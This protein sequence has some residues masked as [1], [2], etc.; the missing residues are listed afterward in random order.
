MAEPTEQ[1]N[2]LF[3]GSFPDGLPQDV[4]GEL[5]SILQLH[6]IEPQELFY[7]WES[8]CMKMAGEETVLNLDTVRSFKRSLHDAIERESR[9]KTQMRGAEKRN[10]GPAAPRPAA[11]ANQGIFD[12]LDDFA[13]NTP[14]RTASG[15]TGSS[16]KRKAFDT[17]T[18]SRFNKG[19]KLDSPGS[20]NTPLRTADSATNGNS[21]TPFSARQNSGQVI[22]TL[23]PDMSM[24]SAPLAPYS[25]SRIRLTA[26]T[27]IKKFSYKPMAMKL[28]EASEILD[29]RIDEFMVVVQKHH[30][31]DDSAFGNAAQQST[32]EVVA[33]GRI[34]SDSPEGKLNTASIV[35][36]TSR[37]TG[38]GLRV[39]LKIDKLQHINF[40]PGQI[41]ALRGINASGEY[42]TVF[43][44]LTIPLLPL[45]VSLPSEVE[46]TNEKLDSFGDQPLNYMF[47]AGPYTT[48][49]NLAFEALNTLCEKAAEECV[50]ALILTGPFIDLEHPL[51]AAGDFDL[52]ELKGLD[53]DTATLTTLF[54]HC[55]SRPLTQLASKVPNIYII[56]I[57]SVR[58]AV[59]KHVSWPQEILPKKE[60]GLPPK[61]AKVVTNPVAISLN[62][63]MVGLCAS[64][65]LYELRRE[66]VV[67]GRPSESDLLS[68]LPRYLIE[69]RHFS[70]VFP[71]TAR[72]NLPK[73]GVEENLQIGSM[74]DT[75]YLKLGDWWKARPDILITPSVL[76]GFVKVVESVLV[77]NPGKL[78]KRRGPGTYAQVAVHP[79]RL[80][81]EERESKFVGHK[82]YERARVDIIRI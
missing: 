29:D 77:I 65:S 12:I 79:K 1:L 71:P 4:L 68:R 76:P 60:L 63:I 80:A 58:D 74:L 64:D 78:S 57:P 45:P 6:A 72:E 16:V 61:Q 51:I 33:V 50:D 5:L 18:N 54:K 8:Y 10:T 15:S 53:P 73:S 41:V 67:G 81:E 24:A 25:D 52:P 19:A 28:S 35:L 56:L 34:A 17:P 13:P 2:E 55:I 43:D 26:N 62:E 42:F 32:R 75:R 37:R 9:A 70:P 44:V 47:A 66:E 46:A 49:D 30:K 39:P 14:K 36:E 48:D 59:S 11:G 3:G 27:D 7:K 31:L 82:V 40:F 38:A 69:Q 22:E 20:V 23:N 21:S